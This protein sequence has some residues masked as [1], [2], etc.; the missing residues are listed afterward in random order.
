MHAHVWAALALPA[1]MLLTLMLTT[2]ALSMPP[3]PRGPQPAVAG[4]PAHAGHTAGRNRNRS[5]GPSEVWPGP[6][7][8]NA[9]FDTVADRRDPETPSRK[10]SRFVMRVCET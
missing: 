8:V 3:L 7:A 6:D 1:L 2:R 4:E 5:R 9:I 10:P